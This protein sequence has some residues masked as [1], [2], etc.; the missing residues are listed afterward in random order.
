M[1]TKRR[2]IAPRQHGITERAC[3]AW[4]QGDCDALR[5]ALGL[6]PWE[7]LPWPLRLTALG[8]DP[9]IRRRPRTIGPG[10]R[11]GRGPWHCRRSFVASPVHRRAS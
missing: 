9:D 2:R 7:I 4:R 3:Q 10:T 6:K 11:A 5:A 8:C 1:P